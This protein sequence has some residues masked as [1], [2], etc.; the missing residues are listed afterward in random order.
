MMQ[1][2]YDRFSYF[3]NT[4]WWRSQGYPLLKGVTLFHLD[5]LVPDEHWNDGTLITV[6]CNSPEQVPITMGKTLR[7]GLKTLADILEG[8]TH[9]QTLL[10]Q[11][12]NAVE[13]VRPL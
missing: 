2:A 1:Q 8:C 7:C 10:W 12:F 3:G 11:L 5:K 9:Q 6:P 13:K 4:S